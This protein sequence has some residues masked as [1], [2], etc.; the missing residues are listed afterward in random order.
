MRNASSLDQVLGDLSTSAFVV[1]ISTEHFAP[2]ADISLSQ[3]TN[4]Q[5]GPDP[6]IKLFSGYLYK[7][8]RSCSRRSNST[9]GDQG[10]LEQTIHF[11]SSY[12][13]DVRCSH[14]YS[15]KPHKPDIPDEMV[16]QLQEC[17][18]MLE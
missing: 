2:A 1:S 8:V 13:A 14:R 12:R 10:D 11:S 17:V 18:E 15:L 7:N 16:I 9:E 5:R 3:A 6:E 4:H